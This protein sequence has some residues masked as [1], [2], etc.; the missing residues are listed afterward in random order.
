MNALE[1]FD[2]IKN[3]CYWDDMPI[4]IFPKECVIVEKALKALE[5]L[6][7]TALHLVSLEEETID[8]TPTYAFYD[9]E[10]FSSVDLTKEEY[11]LLKEV[12]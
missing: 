8:N 2:K 12:L 3:E 5:I 9:A 1:E 7:R 4:V 6:K 11:D 10:L